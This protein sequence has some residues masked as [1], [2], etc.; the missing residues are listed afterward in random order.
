MKLT[1]LILV[2]LPACVQGRL[3]GVSTTDED[4]EL[5]GGVAVPEDRECGY[6]RFLKDKVTVLSDYG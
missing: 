1:Y 4:E 3:E 6:R 2:L 5:V